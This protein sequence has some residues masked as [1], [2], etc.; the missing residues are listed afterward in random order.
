MPTDAPTNTAT[1]QGPTAHPPASVKSLWR[2]R[3]YL[4]PHLL[5]LTIMLG[6]ALAGVGV[7]ILI[8]LQIKA[9][10]D[11]PIAQ[12]D[13]SG[14]L[15]LGLTVLGLGVLEAVLI[16]WRRWTQSN[17]VLSV[18]T[19]MRRDLYD[20]L[21]SLPMSFHSKWQSGSCSRVRPPTC[22][23]SGGSPVSACCS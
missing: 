3:S 23:P 10:I 14:V 20:R 9:L 21:Q 1:T 11:G 15:P 12:H 13:Q 17:A 7:S 2:L 16:W 8:P 18:E 4:R 19:A 6:A 22:R 5:S